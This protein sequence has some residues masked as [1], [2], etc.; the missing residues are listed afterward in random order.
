MRI[1]GAAGFRLDVGET[2][3]GGRVRDA[4]EMLAGWALNLSP[5]V[6]RVA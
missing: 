1:P 3:A 4:D 2:G 6:T 5:G